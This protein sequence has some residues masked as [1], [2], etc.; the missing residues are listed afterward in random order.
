MIVSTIQKRKGNCRTLV[1]DEVAS[2]CVVVDTAPPSVS[3]MGVR[4]Y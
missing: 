1:G 2:L 4:S 3:G